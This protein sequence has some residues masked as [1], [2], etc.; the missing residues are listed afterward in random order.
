MQSWFRKC[1]ANIEHLLCV[2]CLC[3]RTYNHAPTL[4]AC[5]KCPTGSFMDSDLVGSKSIEDCNNC[6]M[7]T[8]QY[9]TGS[10]TCSIA[11][12][13]SYCGMDGMSTPKMCPVNTFSAVYGSTVCE[14]C[15]GNKI[16]ATDFIFENVSRDETY[17]PSIH[18]ASSIPTPTWYLHSDRF[19]V[20]T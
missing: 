4:G 18:S 19:T 17:L 10:T 20:T 13:G 9:F 7:G 5:T 15:P 11:E 6:T 1:A 14:P 3:W 12:P 16:S 2:C 8:Y